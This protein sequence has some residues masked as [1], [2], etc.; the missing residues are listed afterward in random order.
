[1]R[2]L[3]KLL[4]PYHFTLLYLL[5]VYGNVYGRC[6]QYSQPYSLGGGSDAPF[7]HQYCGNLFTAS[8]L[9][10]SS[11]SVTGMWLMQ[12]VQYVALTYLTGECNYGGRVTDEWDRRTLTTL[13][14]KFYCVDIVDADKYDFDESGLYYTPPDGN[15]SCF[16]GL[17]SVPVF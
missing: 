13:L 2:Q 11:L 9:P 16:S 14:K 7:H 4:H 1:M 15:V 3:C 6:S 12:D 8:L 5:P 10:S 17:K